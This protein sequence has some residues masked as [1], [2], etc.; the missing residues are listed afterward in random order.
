MGERVGRVSSYAVSRCGR[1]RRAAV[2][3]VVCGCGGI[4]LCVF[5]F[6]RKRPAA[7]MRPPCVI[8]LSNSTLYSGDFRGDD[9]LERV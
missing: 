1:G 8:Y 7:S 9:P 4:F 5:F 3:F 6:E 2:D